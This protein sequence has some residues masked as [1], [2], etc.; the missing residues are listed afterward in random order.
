M[1]NLPPFVP[2][3]VKE[4]FLTRLHVYTSLSW[5][6]N[7][8]HMERLRSLMG[9]SSTSTDDMESYLA[10]HFGYSKFQKVI[11]F[12]KISFNRSKHLVSHTRLSN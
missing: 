1:D 7:Q 4:A 6:Y 11:G 5:C 8:M 3:Y 9:P 12:L 2:S 10:M